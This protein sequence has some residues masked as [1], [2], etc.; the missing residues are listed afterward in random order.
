MKPSLDAYLQR[1]KPLLGGTKVKPKP[2][3]QVKPYD[4]PL[5]NLGVLQGGIK[6]A[7]KAL[8]RTL[9]DA[10]NP[11]TSSESYSRTE[12]IQ[13]CASGH[14][15]GG[16]GSAGPWRVHRTAK[17]KKQA[18]EKATDIFKGVVG[19]ISGYTGATP[20]L[21]LIALVQEN[22]GEMRMTP[23]G[24]VTHIITT[25]GL[26]GSKM[27]SYLTK[28]R[29]KCKI[30]TPAWI[31][32]SI[33]NGKRL[34]EAK[35]AV[36]A[37]ELQQSIHSIYAPDGVDVRK[38]HVTSFNCAADVPVYAADS[39]NARRL[40]P[41]KKRQE[42]AVIVLTSSPVEVLEL[43]KERGAGGE[44]DDDVELDEWGM[45]VSG[46]RQRERMAAATRRLTKEYADLQKDQPP[47]T[48]GIT[49]DESNLFHWVAYL[50]GPPTSAYKNGTFKI[51][52]T[53]PTDY[54]FKSPQVTKIYHPN[55][56]EEGA[57]CIGLL[58]A[59]AW[60]PSTKIDQA[61]DALVAQIAETY[62]KD[63]PTFTKNAQDYV[64]KYA[65]TPFTG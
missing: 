65:S 64:K 51:D 31:L 13:S 39:V 33:A 10:G 28:R 43:K 2:K 58:K 25:T 32:D 24:S 17:L 18:A 8:L 42:E 60:K 62:Q 6:L 11:L 22:G 48:Q 16:G 55:V 27:E 20:N 56:T 54:P 15:Q 46:Q 44:G 14:Q 4:E 59:D 49:P 41:T 36:V 40:P 34:E 5:P 12:H 26:S 47:F 38:P 29:V 61:E 35:F 1:S 21:R 50:Q 63:R 37:S 23:S 45:P 30:V 57:L 9:K 7:N 53:F 19:H 3:P 52:I